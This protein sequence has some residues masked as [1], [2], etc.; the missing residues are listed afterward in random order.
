VPILS[1]GTGKYLTS[2]DIKFRQG[3]RKGSDKGNKSLDF[4]A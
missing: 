3:S 1:K 4:E 2:V